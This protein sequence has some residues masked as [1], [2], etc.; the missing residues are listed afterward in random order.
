M[1]VVWLGS[2][3]WY[4]PMHAATPGSP[5]KQSYASGMIDAIWCLC[6]QWHDNVQEKHF[7][8]KH[9]ALIVLH[10]ECFYTSAS[11]PCDA[12]TSLAGHIKASNMCDGKWVSLLEY[13]QDLIALTG[14]SWP[15]TL[16][17]ST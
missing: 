1:H 11:A 5:H 8:D 6:G 10:V 13:E 14:E 3:F 16:S 17:C 12:V 7:L 15:F 9:F 2:V 4:R